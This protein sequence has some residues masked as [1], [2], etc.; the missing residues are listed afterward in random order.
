MTKLI[1]I[2]VN[3][4]PSRITQDILKRTAMR[5]K[6]EAEK[7]LVRARDSL[8]V[9]LKAKYPT[10]RPVEVG[11][12]NS[13]T[14]LLSKG[15]V[16]ETPSNRRRGG[17]HGAPFLRSPLAYCPVAAV[18]PEVPQAP[19]VIFESPSFGILDNLDMTTTSDFATNVLNLYNRAQN[20]TDAQLTEAIASD[21]WWSEVE[22]CWNQTFK[23]Q[24]PEV[25]PL[26]EFETLPEF[27]A[28]PEFEM[29][30]EEFPLLFELLK[31]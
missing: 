13:D 21:E 22:R 9:L 6:R 5:R 11:D 3:G 25:T 18:E 2:S 15:Y 16:Y 7:A 12:T 24:E 14:A 20:M 23:P 19:W 30:A 8:K 10:R 26:P 17:G 28:L 29:T 27:E 1:T 31:A 4:R